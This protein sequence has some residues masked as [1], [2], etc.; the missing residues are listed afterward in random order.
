MKLHNRTCRIF[1]GFGVVIDNGTTRVPFNEVGHIVKVSVVQNLL[2]ERLVLLLR[3]RFQKSSV[4]T[5]LGLVLWLRSHCF[6][7]AAGK[8]AGN[9][10]EQVESKEET[11]I[12]NPSP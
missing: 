5:S 6:F 9:D 10:C 12:V 3:N 4:R 2:P 7:R 11:D 1:P 8:L